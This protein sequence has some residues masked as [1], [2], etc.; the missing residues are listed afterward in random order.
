MSLKI[1]VIL[2]LLL[3]KLISATYSQS[4]WNGSS[5]FINISNTI[6]FLEDP[7][8]Q[9]T[10]QQIISGSLDKEFSA[11]KKH[12][13]NFGFNQSV[14][15]LK[16]ELINHTQEDLLLD[17]QHAFIPEAKLYYLSPDGR[18]NFI[19]SGY[20]IHLQDKIIKDHHQ[21]FP[22]SKTGKTFYIKTKP[23]LH[24][25]IVQLWN[26]E[27]YQI[28]ANKQRII[29]GL[30]VG[31][32]L[33]AIII[34][35]FLFFALLKNYYLFYAILV[36]LYI[37]ASAGVMEGYMIYFFPS[38][39]L[40]Y[41]Y[42]IIPVLNMPV[43]L[44][45][46]MS[47]LETQK[48]ST[49]LHKVVYGTCIFLALYIISLHFLPL[50]FVMVTNQILAVVVF[51]ITITTGIIVGK[52]GNKLGYYFTITYSIWFLLLCIEY[53]YIQFGIPDHILGLSYVSIAIFTEAFLLAFLLVKRFQ[54][55]KMAD[56]LSKNEI[57]KDIL[58]IKQ[59]IQNEIMR[60][61]LEMQEQTLMNISQEI[62]D[63]IGQT[64]SLIKLNLNLTI[65]KTNGTIHERLLDSKELLSKAIQ[66]LRDLTKTMNTNYISEISLTSAIEHQLRMIEKTGLYKI[67]FLVNGKTERYKLQNELL[68]FRI[69]QELLNNILK[70]AK[71]TTITVSIQYSKDLLSITVLDNGIGFDVDKTIGE[72]PNGLGLRNIIYRAKLIGG[73]IDIR[74]NPSSGTSTTLNVPKTL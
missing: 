49:V 71:A 34:N 58:H 21:I 36:F 55:D 4:V 74:S 42:L 5:D 17:L 45:Y 13:L 41:W 56:E 62:H 65:D 19:E 2:L 16:F 32:L 15:W 47:F 50:M 60:A 18:W 29:Y 59:S 26:K 69:V 1:K 66:D 23:Y 6:S 8:G 61:Q 30:Y 35:V 14:Y 43:L 63:N 73:I 54:W 72:S 40:M 46:C 22:I 12:M 70:H 10:D 37:G 20:K 24:P 27:A 3:S 64:L 9:L 31:V 68:I 25:I 11:S 38:A 57:K 52:R 67:Q 39:D 44:L 53:V 7:T 33:F 48:A 51:I 28:N